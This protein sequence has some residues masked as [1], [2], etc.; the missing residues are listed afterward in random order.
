MFIGTFT[1]LWKATISFVVSGC[2][3][4]CVEQLISHWTDFHEILYLSIFWK[5]AE[6]IQ[7]LLNPDK[8]NGYFTWRC[9]YICDRVLLNS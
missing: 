4:I 9:M 8:N 7:V 1:K 2:L 5:S 3:P 6:K